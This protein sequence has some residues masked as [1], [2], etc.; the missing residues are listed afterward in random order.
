MQSPAISKMKMELPWGIA[1]PLQSRMLVGTLRTRMSA[2]VMSCLAGPPSGFQPL[3]GV[4]VIAR[5]T[6]AAIQGRN[7]LNVKWDDGPN[8]LYESA[9]Y[10]RQLEETARRAGKVVRNDGDAPGALASAARVVK[11][12][13]YIPHLAHAPMEP[14]AAAAH[15]ADGRCEAWGCTQNPQG[16]RNELAKTLGISPDRVKVNVTL[17]GGGFGRKSKPDYIVE[18]A[19]LS[20]DILNISSSQVYALVRNKQLR[21]IKI[22]G[23]GQYRVERNELEA[24]ISRCYEQTRSFVSAHP[25]GGADEDDFS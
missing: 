13:Y 17:L 11:A 22:G 23:R 16:A 2:T 9:A 25:L 18:A 21:S 12:D 5:N 19:L 6:W 20:A 3:G 8:R 15:V 14:P 1:P 10:R 4:A 24:Y 7:A